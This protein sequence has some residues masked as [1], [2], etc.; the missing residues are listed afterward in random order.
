MGDVAFSRW[1]SVPK[2]MVAPN[3]LWNAAI[4]RRYWEPP[5]CIPKTSS[6]SAA[7]WK[8]I[9]CFC[10]RMASVARKMGTSRSWPQG[11]PYCGWPVTCSRN[12]A[13][14]R[15]CINTPLAGRLIGSPQ[16][17]KGREANPRFWVAPFRCSRTRWTASAWCSFRFEITNS[18]GRRRA[19]DPTASNDPAFCRIPITLV[20]DTNRGRDPLFVP[21]MCHSCLTFPPNWT[22]PADLSR[23]NGVEPGRMI[24]LRC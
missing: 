15:S 5:C 11:T 13:F 3:T 8:V 6:I 7:L 23:C 17:T 2:K 10:C 20:L 1:A 21:L 4:N 22:R 16:S 14:R 24:S 18:P 9:V 12:W 19:M